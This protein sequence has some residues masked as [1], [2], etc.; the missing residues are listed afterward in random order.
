MERKTQKTC[1]FCQGKGKDPFELL[2]ALSTC[3]VCAGRGVIEVKEPSRECVFC[4]G[5]GVYPNTR[6]T[7]TV[8]NGKGFVT[9]PEK[10]VIC[11]SCGGTGAEFESGLSCLQCGGLGVCRAETR[12]GR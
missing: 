10:S 2:S 11:S 8:C 5:S 6:L 9:V 1:R 12:R 7:C 3:Q 4:G